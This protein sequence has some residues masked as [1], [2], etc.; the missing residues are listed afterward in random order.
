MPAGVLVTVTVPVFVTVNVYVIT[1]KVAVTLRAWLMVTVHAPVPV[2]A[3]LQPVKVL[4]AAAAAV[5]VSDEPKLE[6]AVHVAPQSMP[7]GVLVSAPAPGP[8]LLTV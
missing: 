7:A 1:A 6:V 3:P 2:Q 4:P 8:D 5:N